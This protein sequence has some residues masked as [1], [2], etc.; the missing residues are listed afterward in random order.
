MANLIN[1]TE[2]LRQYLD[3]SKHFDFE[4]ILIYIKRVERKY[5]Q[6]LVGR[7]QY[8][9]LCAD[10]STEGE[11]F[12]VREVFR[13][14][15][16]NYGLVM[17]LPILNSKVTNT[18]TRT[19]ENDQSRSSD[20]KEVRD[21]MRTCLSAA[22]E[23]VDE[24]LELMEAKPE[25]F[26]AWVDSPAYTVF[27][28]MFV[29]Q[30][31]EFNELFFI[32]NSR[33]TFL[34]LRPIMKEMQERYLQPLLKECYPVLLSGTA[35]GTKKAREYAQKAIVALTIATVAETGSFLF[36]ATG[37][38]RYAEELPWERYGNALSD[39]QLEKLRCSRQ[40]AGEEYLKKLK[41]ELKANPQV[42]PCYT[43]TE[44]TPLSTVVIK[45]KSGLFL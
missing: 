14:A 15:V 36:T 9:I 23:A 17:H 1:S 35:E 28:E 27:S 25:S 41:A 12:K 3:V 13:E 44:N 21:L 33:V 40:N 20:W 37:L 43:D 11:I 45:K 38:F 42:F 30:T 6:R 31:G 19:S 39:E 4:K 34:A 5:V 29:K 32:N 18:G 8:T 10:V 26:S 24:A 16:A 2:D 7:E 22:Y